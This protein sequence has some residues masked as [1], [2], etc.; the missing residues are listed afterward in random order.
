MSGLLFTGR[1]PFCHLGK[2]T[3]ATKTGIGEAKSTNLRGKLYDFKVMSLG[4][5]N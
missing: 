4:D 3:I 1:F 2:K 5:A